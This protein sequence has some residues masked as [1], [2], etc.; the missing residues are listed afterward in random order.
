MT[1]SSGLQIVNNVALI[2]IDNPPVNALSRRT[3][4]TLRAE[5]QQ[6]IDHPQ[7]GAIILTGSKRAFSAGADISELETESDTPPLNGLIDFVRRAKKTIIAAL[8]GATLGGGLELALACF[9]RIASP[10][11]RLGFPEIKLG[12]IPG[13]GGTQFLPRLIG[14]EEALRF[15]LSG[16]SISA[17]EA[18]DAGLVDR[19][20]HEDLI[21]AAIDFASELI[22]KPDLA[23]A[24]SIRA[25]RLAVVRENPCVLDDIASTWLSGSG[26]RGSREAAQAA[27]DSVRLS[28]STSLEDGLAQERLI[29]ARLRASKQSRARRYIFL[30]ERVASKWGA[31]PEPSMRKQIA[32][33]SV[34]GGGFMGAAIAWCC[35]K[36]AI[37]TTI[38][39]AG[40]HEVQE[41]ERRLDDLARRSADREGVSVSDVRHIRQ[42]ITT[43][44]DIARVCDAGLVIEAVFE[45]FKVKQSV[46]E[47][48]DRRAR[49]DAI[50]ATNT[51]Y[52]SV[53]RLTESVACPE[54][55]VGLH[56]FSPAQIMQL[57]EVVR[58]DA[59]SPST[60]SACLDFCRRIGKSPVISGSCEGFIG[61]RMLEVRYN[62]AEK[63]LL[64]G[65]LPHQVDSAMTSFGFPMGP[66]AI[67]D[68][69]GLEI[70]W[71]RR[72]S[73]GLP[74]PIADRLC[75]E[76]RFGRKVG[77]GFYLYDG[78]RRPVHDPKV[79]YLIMQTS[80][81]LGILRRDIEDSEIVERLL[82]PMV[83]EGARILEEG[84]AV[85]PGDID[86]VWARGFGWP[87]SSGGP[88]FYADAEGLKHIRDRLMEWAQ[89]DERLRPVKLLER[90]VS[91][92]GTFGSLQQIS[93]T[94]SGS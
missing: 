17:Q 20:A 28:L 90:L 56:F 73:R 44:D 69:C 38:V 26:E 46:F 71:S 15:I 93:R 80:E 48:L 52:L 53:E 70:S 40:T 21:S 29:F 27:L 18:L 34:V 68:M 59:T 9:S 45:D 63:L 61:N 57:V 24:R 10:A 7:V 16:R 36:A 87:P 33:V 67:E 12:L 30:A 75:A 89:A 32:S 77:C 58:T 50:L 5:L 47:E 37:P 65:A 51:S 6:A 83:N 3:I 25:D 31:D 76:G 4:S 1:E 84:I 55:I 22:R 94:P 42:S 13:A 35:A 64:E 41:T 23:D 78:N 19:V 49:A 82:Y 14:S 2:R 88:F 81:E 72:K 91:D 39:E 11:A 85:R 92:G 54:R 60:L 86:V 43:Y 8:D 66:F 79:D 74:A 62:E